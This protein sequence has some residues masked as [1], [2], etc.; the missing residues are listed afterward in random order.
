[1]IGTRLADL[2]KDKGMSQQEL[3][4]LLLVSAK[5][6]SSY[7]NGHSTPDDDSKVLIA[8]HFNVSLDYLLGVID[9]Q[10]ML[11]RKNVVIL[12][13]YFPVTAKKEI[14]KHIELL[15]FKYKSLI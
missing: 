10:L 9:N 11:D 12:P 14:G 5:T 13:E 8:K 3:A 6:I 7:E 15:S 1:M 4:E 2:R